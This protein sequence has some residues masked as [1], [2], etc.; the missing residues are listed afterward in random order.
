AALTLSMGNGPLGNYLTGP[1]GKTL[2]VFLKDAPNTSNCTGACLQTWPPL[3]QE[4]DQDV[5]GASGVSGKIGYIDTAAGEQVTY[6]GAPLYYFSKDTAP[7]QTQGNLVTNLWYVARPESASTAVVGMRSD[8]GKSY[9]VGPTGGTLYLFAKDTDGVTNCSGS[10]AQN[11]P[12]LTVPQG[13]DPTAVSS[14]SG[15]LAVITRDDGSRQ[16]TYNGKPVYYYAGD[17]LPGDTNGD[18]VGGVWSL[19][20]S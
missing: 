15:S 20:K 5:K 16:V 13:I 6:N 14:A 2:Y 7:G 3:L 10:C 4:E 18:G 12:A 9:L 19:A 17:K 11:W 1:D 8:N